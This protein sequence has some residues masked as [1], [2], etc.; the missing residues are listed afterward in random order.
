MNETISA[1]TQVIGSLGFPI[2]MCIL[3]FWY[4]KSKDEAHSEE[5]KGYLNA[6]NALTAKIDILIAKLDSYINK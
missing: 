5:T 4:V 1:I 3:M 6:I 2:G